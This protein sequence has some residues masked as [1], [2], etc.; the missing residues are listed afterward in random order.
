MLCLHDCGHDAH[1]HF[2]ATHGDIHEIYNMGR[3]RDTHRAARTA[4]IAAALMAMN[5]KLQ[6]ELTKA[7]E[8]V[9]EAHKKNGGQI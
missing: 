8:A 6:I 4:A 5:L 2:Y 3:Y 9:A 7:L 1:E